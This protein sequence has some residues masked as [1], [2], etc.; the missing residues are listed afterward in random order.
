VEGHGTNKLDSERDKK[1]AGL[2]ASA[3]QGDQ[4]AYEGF[5]IETATILRRYLSKR[6]EIDFVEDVLQETLL[7]IH[8]FLH[9]YLTGRPVGPWLYAICNNRMVDFHRR[10]RR[11]QLVEAE[12]AVDERSVVQISQA[13]RFMEGAAMDALTKLPDRQRR[14][15]EL[16]K[17]YGWTVK[18]VAGKTGMSEASV[19]VTAFRGYEAIRKLFGI[20]T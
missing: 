17:V 11:I 20:K 12:V 19:K 6:M 7:S 16:L 10:K 14:V 13:N 4:I 5:L 9:T 15:I 2:L 3:Q 18:E 1:L 8:R